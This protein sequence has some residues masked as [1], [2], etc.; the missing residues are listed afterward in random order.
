[1]MVYV[2]EFQDYLRLPTDF[3]DA[4]AQARGL[5]VAF[6]LAHQYMHQLDPAMRSAV[7]ANTQS[8]I[9][10]RLAHDDAR[11]IAAGSALDPEDFQS[12]GAYQCYTQLVADGAVQPWCSAKTRVPVEPISD[13]EVARAAS[14]QRYGIDRD[15]VEADIRKLVFG[16]REANVDDIGPRRRTGGAP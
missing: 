11:L 8:R 12:L 5:G 6:I 13:P 9:A 16:R 14:R 2:D 1:V 3:A 10:F 4:L 7:L 15:E